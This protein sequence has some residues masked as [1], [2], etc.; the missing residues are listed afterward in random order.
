MSKFSNG[1]I[2]VLW[3]CGIVYSIIYQNRSYHYWFFF[4]FSVGGPPPQPQNVRYESI[5]P[6][7]VR[8]TWTLPETVAANEI[9]NVRFGLGDEGTPVEY[10][11]S[12]DLG[13][14]ATSY[15]AE[16]LR[17]GFRY[18]IM[19]LTENRYGQSDPV[20]M[21][22]ETIPGKRLFS[23]FLHVYCFVLPC[24]QL[25]LAS[26]DILFTITRNCLVFSRASYLLYRIWVMPFVSWDK[27]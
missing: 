26:Q 5:S 15:T 6:T 21:T 19:V 25:Q 11:S 12:S 4:F 17:P 2:Q 3:I 16:Q 13:V 9:E 1:C 24:L 14:D 22:V 8:V 20:V 7:V 27:T 23:V 18:T 10:L